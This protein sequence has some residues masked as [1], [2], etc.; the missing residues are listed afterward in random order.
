MAGGNTGNSGGCIPLLH[1]KSNNWYQSL[2][3]EQESGGGKEHAPDDTMTMLW[4]G[5]YRHGGC[6]SEADGNNL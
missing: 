4:S 2:V 3:K 6:G 1:R 5:T